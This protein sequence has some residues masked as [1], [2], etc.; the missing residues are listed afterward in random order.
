VFFQCRC[1]ARSVDIHTEH[2]N[3]G[4]SIEFKDSPP[5]MLK[6]LD[7]QPLWVYKRSLEL[8]MTK[9]L[10][11][12]KDIIAAFTGIGNLVCNALG[13]DLIYGLP[14]SHF[15][16]ALLWEPRDAAIRRENEGNEQFP[17]WAWCG[18]AKEIMEYKT[19][20]LVGCEDNLHDWLMHHTW[21]TWYIRDGSGNLRLVW[22]RNSLKRAS[23]ATESRWRGYTC[24]TNA[25]PLTYDNYGRFINPSE[26]S[27]RSESEFKMILDECPYSVNITEYSESQSIASTEKDMPFLQFFTWRAF[28]RIR[29][30]RRPSRSTFGQN[31]IRYSVLDSKEDWCG[32]IILD[33]FW[34]RARKPDEPVE[35]IALSDAKQFSDVEYDDWANYIPIDQEESTWD[36]YYTL[37][38]EQ[39]AGISYRVGLGKVFKEAFHNSCKPGGKEWKEFILG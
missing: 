14:S 33:K 35:F 27:Y 32:T 3:A 38:I 37:L 28:F 26:R 24:P 1:T 23:E 17:S 39:K 12:A 22:D 6:K 7:Q 36:L 18:W 20:T 11:R 31:F 29:E 30:D 4:W 19:S 13:G 8:Y 16:W 2:E 5:L 15:D 25:D 9:N 10:T 34:A 21:I